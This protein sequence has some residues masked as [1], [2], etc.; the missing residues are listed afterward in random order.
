MTS[1]EYVG[2]V[3]GGKGMGG[4]MEVQGTG[5]IIAYER[6]RYNNVWCVPKKSSIII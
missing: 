6:D 5:W 3:G 4:G 1:L 2:R